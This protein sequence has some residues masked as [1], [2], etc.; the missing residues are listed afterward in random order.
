MAT[1][2]L[3][4]NFLIREVD[5][6]VGSIENI[7][8]TTGAIA[9]PFGFGPVDEITR[10]TTE[11][12]LLDTFGSP[13]STDRQYEYWMSAANYLGYGGVLKV[14]RTDD[15]DLKNAAAGVGA[16]ASFIQLPKLRTT[17]TT[18]S[19]ILHASSWYFAGKTPGKYLKWR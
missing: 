17:I 14:V 3:S 19:R 7:L 11:Q 9:G 4:P 2:Q 12:E 15:D 5:L 1:P 16:T 10:I 8:D 6:T 18:K 13:F